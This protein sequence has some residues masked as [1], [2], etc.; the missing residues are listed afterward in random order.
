MVVIMRLFQ[1]LVTTPEKNPTAGVVGEAVVLKDGHTIG[2]LAGEESEL[3]SFELSK[4]GA[5]NSGS[6]PNVL[7]N[8]K[9]VSRVKTTMHRDTVF[10][11][12]DGAEI[13]TSTLR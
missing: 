1:D 5:P 9:G 8:N 7:A 10:E 11:D 4:S 12:S 13:G 2:E 6:V 3:K